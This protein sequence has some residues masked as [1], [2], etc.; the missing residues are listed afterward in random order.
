MSQTA[1]VAVI[2]AIAVV[3]IV[4]ALVGPRAKRRRKINITI[5]WD[6]GRHPDKEVPDDPG[7]DL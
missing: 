3:L 7:N 5:E 4:R 2:V 6:D 1:P